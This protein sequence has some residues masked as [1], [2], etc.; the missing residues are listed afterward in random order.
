MSSNVEI[1]DLDAI[2]SKENS[3]STYNV[4]YV[5]GIIFIIALLGINIFYYLGEGTEEIAEVFKPVAQFFAGLFGYTAVETAKQTIKTSSAGAKS[6]IDAI[7]KGTIGGLDL[8][9]DV[10]DETTDERN[11]LSNNNKKVSDNQKKI[12]NTNS[13]EPTSYTETETGD[14]VQNTKSSSKMGYCYIGTDRGNRS[15]APIGDET[16]CMSGSI[17]PTH[18]TCINPNLRYQEQN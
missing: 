12:I 3:I 9:E 18:E 15:C 17:F 4:A 1:K 10:L 2:I 13:E 11:K 5:L 16:M 8:T 7:E 14:I 6:G